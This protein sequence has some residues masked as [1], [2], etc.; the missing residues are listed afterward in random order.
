MTKDFK[1]KSNSYNPRKKKYLNLFA[2]ISLVILF[3]GGNYFLLK[4][5]EL[6]R[7]Q[8][9]DLHSLQNIS[10]DNS[11]AVNISFS[12][13][14]GDKFIDKLMEHQVSYYN[15]YAISSVISQKYDLR[16]IKPNQVVNFIYNKNDHIIK[17]LS[18]HLDNYHDLYAN[19]NCNN[20]Y[21]I[22]IKDAE[23]KK[24]LVRFS[25][26]IEY[27]IYNLMIKAG[28][29]NKIAMD[30]EKLYTTRL[31]LKK[32]ITQ[33]SSIDIIFERYEDSKH[34][35][36]FDG[37][38]IY[39]SLTLKNHQYDFYR[40]S[41]YNAATK[42]IKH[43][44]YFDQY[45]NGVHM[46]NKLFTPPLKVNAPIS[47]KFGFRMHPI[48]KRRILHKGIDYAVSKGTPVYASADGIVNFAKKFGGYGN[49]IQ[50]KHDINYITMY[51][52]LNSF[53]KNIKKGIKIYKGNLIG[54]SGDTGN[55][56]GAHL[57][58]EMRYKNKA[59]DPNFFFNNY[60]KYSLNNKD[61][62]DF[63]VKYIKFQNSIINHEKNT[64]G[65][66]MINYID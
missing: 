52:H 7:L 24:Y 41:K 47:S 49:T 14:Y 44:G 17:E 13:N 61:L 21:D 33:G 22:N 35:Q 4:D 1:K 3:F 55:V 62:K 28:I 16:K 63:M 26:V 2:F 37:D 43:I 30:I 50:I 19:I 51:A 53:G 20:S 32:S 45:G 12:I 66:Q 25:S 27:S 11:N 65:L 54:Y 31:N 5:N 59:L 57:H 34:N 18:I 64:N 15:A 9:N 39:I 56:T 58:Y 60:K 42:N 29:S 48:L 46:E 36:Q 10:Q 40:Y 8:Y 38:I 23:Y 6:L